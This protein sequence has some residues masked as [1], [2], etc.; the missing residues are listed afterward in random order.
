MSEKIFACFSVFL[1]LWYS[2]PGP[3]EEKSKGYNARHRPEAEPAA[4]RHDLQRILTDNSPIARN[5][6]AE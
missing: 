5:T 2:S 4:A 3:N 6:K 1:I